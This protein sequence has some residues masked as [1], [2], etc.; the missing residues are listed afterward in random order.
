LLVNAELARLGMAR[1]FFCE[2]NWKNCPVTADQDRV[3]IIKQAVGEAKK[4][5]AGLYGAV[6]AKFN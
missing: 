6:C 1:E 5:K 2:S 4:N 3:K